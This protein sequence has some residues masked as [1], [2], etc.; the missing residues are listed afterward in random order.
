[1]PVRSLHSSTIIWPT[2][3]EVI[4]ALEPW[5]SKLA[6]DHRHIVAIGYFGSYAAG[7]SGVGS[8]LD[9]VVITE[10]T[11]IPR[12]RRTLTFPLEELPVPTD[13][14][15]FT[16]SEWHALQSRD[17]RFARMM[18]EETIWVWPEAQGANRRVELHA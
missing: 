7:R 1:M 8:D 16:T 3:E 9:L 15:V 13:V 14:L 6:R 5:A 12:E 4:A 18:R 2:A 17:T 10:E 11:G